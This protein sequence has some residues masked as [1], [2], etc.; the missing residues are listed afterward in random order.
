MQHALTV[1]IDALELS[2][3]AYF[4]IAFALHLWSKTMPRHRVSPGQLELDLSPAAVAAV[5]E[6]LATAPTVEQ[7][8][9]DAIVP[10]NRPQPA[11]NWSAM[12]PYELR[13]VCQQQGIKWRNAHGK[14]RHLTKLQM[15]AALTA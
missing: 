6:N 8:W 13:K 11:Y 10:F 1:S 14:N 9:A 15:I 4:A 3:A 5:A 7:A 2:A 12:S